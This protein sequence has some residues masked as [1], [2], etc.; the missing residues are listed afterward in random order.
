MSFDFGC[1]SVVQGQGVDHGWASTETLVH[2]GAI[3]PGVSTTEP[4]PVLPS[5]N[6]ATSSSWLLRAPS[7]SCVC[8]VL[9]QVTGILA[10]YQPPG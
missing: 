6:L 1:N 5:T 4:E 8:I 3:I 2:Q 9:T 10:G 7:A